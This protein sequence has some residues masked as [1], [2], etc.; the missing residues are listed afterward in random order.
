MNEQPAPTFPAASVGVQVTVV[1]PT[2]KDDPEGGT[3]LT[4]A[5]GQ[6][7]AT[8][9]AVKLTVIAAPP[10]VGVTAVMFAG[11]LLDKVGNCVSF[12]FTVKVQEEEEPSSLVAVTVTVVVPT[13]KNEPD[14]GLDATV[15]Q[16]P[17]RVAAG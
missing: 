10:T 17:L 12:T 4:V 7:S 3:Q 1:V 8:V 11:Q 9:G 14:A 16:L 2:G 15:P 6:L 5:P 13:G